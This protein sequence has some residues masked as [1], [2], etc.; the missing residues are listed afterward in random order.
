MCDFSGGEAHCEAGGPDGLAGGVARG[1]CVLALASG[2]TGG[3]LGVAGRR[4]WK[5]GITRIFFLCLFFLY[6]AN[7][8]KGKYLMQWYH[9]T[10]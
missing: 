8:I 5:L 10:K 6:S 1:G 9:F 4:C 3:R 2:A 7:G